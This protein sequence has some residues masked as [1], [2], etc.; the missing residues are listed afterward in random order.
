[1]F[2]STFIAS[3]V[4]G[5]A[6]VSAAT[7]H[8]QTIPGLVAAYGFEEGSG[9][10]IG[11][12]SGQNNNGV[13]SGT[14]WSTAGKFGNALVFNGTNAQVTVP[15]A[16][17]LQL[18]T[19]MT[20]EAWVFPT[21]AP[22]G[23]RAIIDKN[24]DGYYLMGSTD[25][26]NRPGAGGTWT[27]GNKNVFGTAV[28]PAN[29]W[30]HL[31]TTFDG[32]AVRLFVNG[33]QVAS[34]AQTVQLA[35][36]TA[37]LQIG[38]DAYAGEN[39]AG[40]IDEV[41]VYNRALSAAEIQADMGVAIGTP[42][43]PV[44]DTVAP[45]APGT[46][47]TT[48]SGSTQVTLSW[49]AATDNVGVTGYRVERCAGAGCS[50]F[51]QIATPTGTSFG[52]TGL[53]AGTSYS[54]RVRA[55]DAAGNL[56][57]Y[58]NV[59]S[60]TTTTPDTTPPSAPS[61][62]SATAASATQINLSWAAA[63]DN[64]GVT[65]YRVER[66][67][68]DGCTTFAQIS[69]PTATTF[70]NTG[71]TA[72]TSY[73]YR[74]L[75]VDAAGNLSAYSSVASATTLAVPD[76]TAPTAP[77]GLSA[78]VA[79]ATQVDLAWTASTDNV[80]VTSYQI[81][82]CQG[83]TTC[84][85]FAPVGTSTVTSFSNTGLTPST[86][87]RFRVRAVDG[88]GNVSGNSNTVNATTT[89]A[90]DTTPPSA[91]GGLAAVATSQSQI[92]VSWTAAT[93]NVGV[94]GYQL[95]RCSGSGC[96]AFAQIAAPSATS[97]NDTGLTASTSY[98]YRARAVDGAGNLGSYSSVASATTLAPDLTPPTAPTGFTATATSAS[99]V[100]L[101]WTASTDNVA[102]TGYILQRCLGAGCSAWTTIA[103]PTGTTYSDTGLSATTTYRYW[104]RATDAA[105]NL[106]PWS[107]I[108]TVTTLTPDTSGL[109][110]AFGF[111][112][113]A[114]T[115]I[116]DASSQNN[117][118]V[119]SNTTWTTGKFGNALVF[120]GTNSQVTIA[121]AP[122]LRLT[123]AATLEAWVFPTSAPTGW[124]AIIDKNVDGYYLFASTDN[125]NRPA[126]GGTWTSGNQ[127]TFGPSAIPVNSWTHLATTFDGTTVRL[128]VNGVQVASQAQTAQLAPTTGT[129][130]IGADFYPTEYFAGLIDE[131]R[132][133][134]RALSPAEIQVDMLT[135]V[136]GA[137]PPPQTDTTPPS[138]NITSP[139]NGATV[140]N[141]VSVSANAT[142]NV[143]VSSVQFLLDGA[144]LGSPVS[145][146]PFSV[147]W[148]T[149]TAVAGN[150]TLQA[151][152]TDFAGNVSTSASVAVTVGTPT[153]STA[154]Q[155]AAPVTW[156]IV[157]VNAA[158]LPTG[159]ILAWDGQDFGN[160]ARVWSPATG[161]FANVPNTLTNMFCSGQCLLP[162]GRAL[163]VGGHIGAHV[164]L[165]DTNIFDP[166]TR[167]WSRMAPMAV[168]RWY[169]T[170]TQLPDGRMLVT[171]GEID[172][173]GC[174]AP[175][176][177]VYD[178]Q[179]DHWTQLTGASQSFPYYPHMFVLSDGRVLAASTTEAPI[180]SRVL[181]IA[182]QTWSV[183]DPTA[184]DGGSAA[185]YASGKILKSG[186]SV[187]PD[188][189]VIP[190]TAT[191]YVLDMNQ[192]T[193]RWRQT[194]PMN[195]ARTFHTLT[196]LPDG[197][198][199]A[200]G[201]G[202]DTN[203][204]GVDNAVL[205]AE[206]WSPVTETWTTLASMSR[207]RLYHSNALLLPDAR[208]LILGGGRFNGGDAPTDQKSSEIFSPPYLFKGPRPVIASAPS[209]T[210][211]GTNISVQTPDAA[212]IGSVVLMKLGTVTHSFNTNQR[213]VPLA[214]TA[215]SGTLSVQT[216]ANANL[217]PPGHYMLF[218]LN[219]NGVPSVASIVQL[220]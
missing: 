186:R 87:Y 108:V 131:V 19:G 56:G 81:L 103:T 21:T 70:N 135:P 5:S 11:D 47:T 169:P 35:P 189:P 202:P 20:L 41:R 137:A 197:T 151:R 69:T 75:A 158:L 45:S 155:W 74:V 215:G 100:N 18:T 182:T 210:T 46:L 99:Q 85:T 198:V 127:N 4:A 218:I 122:S 49:G 117:T 179:L 209:A 9:T 145:N 25:N 160:Q 113:G 65:G 185:M 220:Q 112:E 204:V 212:S 90:P 66:C 115:A 31:A 178:P 150:H 147:A 149:A 174:Y 181:N 44:L 77:T 190:S 184:V 14:T 192:A 67:Q 82:R 203:A 2:R 114:G 64:V 17:S 92:S 153:G 29:T 102:V 54:Y 97:F 105:G 24:V 164:G 42:P 93:D 10:T 133:Y 207:P 98:S 78:K 121:D 1:M 89:A 50:T 142:D 86:I 37:T 40:L 55:T 172:C 12:L 128:F 109:V 110:A 138:V 71:L 132:I 51:A 194:A 124:R 183:V 68:G 159:E 167:A 191:T 33:V 205:A 180:V 61:A 125:G 166:A 193:P 219:T 141:T 216:P 156:P 163:V 129:L 3:I 154:G 177:E 116:R 139:A 73:S 162:D 38:G 106:S 26:G 148:D 152:A 213:I 48:A 63:T 94:I 111:D 84:T 52:D 23:W 144:A 211:Y 217:A 175:I 136:S 83:S 95:E 32:T 126:G 62:L 134:N 196:V 187:D 43:P 123:T 171:S 79:G 96:S 119:A 101:S 173:G 53:T 91:P 13:A 88:A 157:A 27:N 39:F 16:A 104:V 214:F 34:L 36:T 59:A 206:L 28:L 146:A 199:L 176:P 195:F 208:V 188:Q 201:G 130:Q 22:T 58:S 57:G 107:S 76:T 8:A 170:V 6:F 165:P 143:G 200:T 72:S 120:N 161:V 140:T 80:G 118:G 7:V 30:T 15:N 168:G 60:A